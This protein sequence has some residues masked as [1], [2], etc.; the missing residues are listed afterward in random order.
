MTT[1]TE[2]MV[3]AFNEAFAANDISFMADN[4][5]ENVSWCKVGERTIAGKQE[6][7]NLLNEEGGEGI[8]SLTIE[9]VVTHGNISMC[10]GRREVTNASGN[11]QIFEFCEVYKLNHDGR[12]KELIS[13]AI[14]TTSAQK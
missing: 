11:K 5:T 2:E 1:K 13:Y 8:F 14:N 10:N 7:L 4:L 6:V 12:I 9:H 3:R